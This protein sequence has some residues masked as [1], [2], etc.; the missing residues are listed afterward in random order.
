MR[1]ASVVGE[2]K[3]EVRKVPDPAIDKDEV[4]I[5]IKYCGICGSDLHVY[6]SG[7][8]IAMGHEISGDIAAVGAEVKGWKVGDRVL[9]TGRGGCGGCVWCKRGKAELCE[10]C[11]NDFMESMGSYTTYTKFKHTQLY[12]LPDSMSYE[13]AALVE[14]TSCS[15]HAVRRS[16]MRKGDTVAVF[17]LGA[18]GQLAVRVAKA[19]GA[20]AVYASEISPARIALARG[21]AD[22]VIDANIT[23]PVERILELTD[24]TGTDIVLECAGS[25]PTTQQAMATIRKAG[26]IVIVGICFDWV[27]LPVNNIML[28][29]LTVTGALNSTV[30]EF[31]ESFELIRDKKI[32][33][34]SLATHKI[35]LDEINE[36]FEIAIRGECGKIMIEP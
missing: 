8:A 36:A 2:R 11:F 29:E 6:K 14:P 35:P 15:L 24:G 18:I 23:N 26:T 30:D 33:V 9:P 31:T 5:K 7:A 27:S 20:R 32:N 34:A 13:E 12:K 22:E 10:V 1:A 17:G 4:L 19:L 21:E 28:K 25:V 16:G 3:I